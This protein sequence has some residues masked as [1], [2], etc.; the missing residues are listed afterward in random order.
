MLLSESAEITAK[1]AHAG[2]VSA[3]AL[4]SGAFAVGAF[5][6]GALAVGALAIGAL[7]IRRLAVRQASFDAVRIRDLTVERLCVKE[8]RREP[9]CS[10]R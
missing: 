10:D 6:I 9:P 2:A 7:A 1:R 8:F 4:A 5:A 3:G